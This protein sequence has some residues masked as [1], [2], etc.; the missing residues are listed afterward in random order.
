MLRHSSEL[1]TS[2]CSRV[3]SSPATSN[4]MAH[5]LSLMASCGCS[6]AQLIFTG[7]HPVLHDP[8]PD[9]IEMPLASATGSAGDALRCTV[10]EP[11][12]RTPTR[13][14]PAKPRAKELLPSP[15]APSKYT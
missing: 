8:G 4:S 2:C 6:A 13:R 12:R 15:L 11:G 3:S 1:T 14:A 7:L 10:E 5:C 9:P